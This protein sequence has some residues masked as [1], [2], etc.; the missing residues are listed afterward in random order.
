LENVPRSAVSLGHQLLSIDT[1]AQGIS[2]L[3]IRRGP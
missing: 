1:D 2:H 3:S